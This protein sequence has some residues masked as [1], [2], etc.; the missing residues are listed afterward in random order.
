MVEVADTGPGIAPE[1][2]AE[3]FTRFQRL[4]RSR[5]GYG[6]GLSLVQA[7]VRAHNFSIAISGAP[8]QGCIVRLL[9]TPPDSAAPAPVAAPTAAAVTA[10]PAAAASRVQTA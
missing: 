9:C 5:E 3:V 6:L 1:H 2:R 10:A 4:D 7:I 8:G